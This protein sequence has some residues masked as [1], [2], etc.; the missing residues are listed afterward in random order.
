MQQSTQVLSEALNK[1]INAYELLQKEN[2]KL[3]ETIKELQEDKAIM[4]QE[5]EDLSSTTT[6]Q[7]EDINSM[8]G[9]IES[10]LDFGDIL[11]TTSQETNIYQED[12]KDFLLQTSYESTML[13][14]ELHI[15]KELQTPNIATTL[16]ENKEQDEEDDGLDFQKMED[17][18]LTGFGSNH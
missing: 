13:R 1:L 15:E 8:L 4:R 5:I 11:T 14:E 18:L 17:L 2:A 12:D 9:K 7:T 3:N 6:K 16:E 10:L